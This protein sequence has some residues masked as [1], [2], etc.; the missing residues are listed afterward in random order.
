MLHLP[1]PASRSIL[2]AQGSLKINLTGRLDSWVSAKDVILKILKIFTTK[3]NVGCVFEYGG[4]GVGTLTVPERATITN[5]GAECGVT[6][7]IF[8]SDEQ[9]RKFLRAQAREKEWEKMDADPDAEYSK[10]VEINLS[11][12]VPLAATPHSPGN[13]ST[14]KELEGMEVNQVCV[15][16][17]TNSLLQ[18]PDDGCKKF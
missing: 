9:T 11:E 1:W 8:P 6:T 18:R 12:L 15:G 2:P 13:I 4:P 7:S 16:S 17:C 10:I 5:M 14:V 3:G